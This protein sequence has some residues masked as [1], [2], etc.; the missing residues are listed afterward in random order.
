MH[1]D[2]DDR[3]LLPVKSEL[4]CTWDLLVKTHILNTG[5]YGVFVCVCVCVFFYGFFTGISKPGFLARGQNT[6]FYG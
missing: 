1:L 3:H 4:K 2:S 6:G 5:F